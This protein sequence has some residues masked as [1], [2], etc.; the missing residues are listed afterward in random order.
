MSPLSSRRLKLQS[1]RS[2]KVLYLAGWSG[3]EPGEA[4][5][6]T[7][8]GQGRPPAR[9]GCAAG[10]SSFQGLAAARRSSAQLRVLPGRGG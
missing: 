4:R 1:L 8:A 5:G 6:G 9:S 2:L 10:Q 3:L 7:W